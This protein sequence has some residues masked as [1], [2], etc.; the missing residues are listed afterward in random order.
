VAKAAIEALQARFPSNELMEAFRIFDPGYATRDPEAH[1]HCLALGNHYFPDQVAV[2]E[3]QWRELNAAK[4]A[5]EESRAAEIAAIS[6]SYKRESPTTPKTE[7]KLRTHLQRRRKLW[8]LMLKDP[9]AFSINCNHY[10]VFH[11][12]VGSSF[13]RLLMKQALPPNTELVQEIANLS[14]IILG[15]AAN[16]ERMFALQRCRKRKANGKMVGNPGDYLLCHC[17]LLSGKEAWLF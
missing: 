5:M 16:V 6:V 12:F 17:G 14:L 7:D 9:Q 8:E 2:F 15:N 1:I 13:L 10:L 11:S 4:E 3:A